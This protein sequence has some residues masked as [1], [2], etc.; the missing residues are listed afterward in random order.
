MRQYDALSDDAVTT[1]WDQTFQM[2]EKGPVS[3]G[4]KD[5]FKQFILDMVCLDPARRL[6]TSALLQ[7]KYL[8][9]VT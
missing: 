2:I 4:D 9:D 6:G 5:L 8:A 7:H 3:V 1:F